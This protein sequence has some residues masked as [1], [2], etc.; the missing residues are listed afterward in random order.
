M[1][2]HI[3]GIPVESGGP[4]DRL[5]LWDRVHDVTGISRTTAWRLSQVGKFPTQVSVS[6]G[7]VGWWESELNAWKGLR[8]A[9]AAID[10]PPRGRGRR[11]FE[12][13]TR[14]RLPGM[15]RPAPTRAEGAAAKTPA[16]AAAPLAS[17]TRSGPVRRRK[18]RPVHADQID[19]GF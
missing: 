13:P 5:L 16:Q 15:S 4:D 18:S 11:T 9:A 19:F 2:F 12:P 6:P 1:A 7:R 3:E 17:A 8:V 14:P 10:P